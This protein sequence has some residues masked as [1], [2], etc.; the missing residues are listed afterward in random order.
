MEFIE[1]LPLRELNYLANMTYKEYKP[2]DSSSSKNEDERIKNYE[3]MKKTCESFIKA[4]G[5]IKR[6]YKFTGGNNWKQDGSGSGRLFAGCGSIQGLPKKLRGFLLRNTTTDIDMVNCHPVILQYLCNKHNIKSDALQFYNTHREEV[7]SR[8]PDRDKGKET[9]LKAVNDDKLNKKEKD[10]GFKEFDKE[11]KD[12]QK[13]LT[14]LTCYEQIVKDVPEHRLY[15]W[16]GSAINRILCYYENQ[17]LQNVITTIN[18]LN[19]EICCPMFDGAMPYGDFYDNNNLL[20]LIEDSVEKQFEGLNMKFAYKQH[21]N[22]IIMPDDYVIPEKR[23]L[24]LHKGCIFANNDLEASNAIYE[25][26]KGN[27]IYS[28]NTLYYKCNHLWIDNQKAIECELTNFIQNQK[29]YKT[30]SKEEIID[31]VQNIKNAK[32]V[33]QTL[34]N[35]VIS[36]K[37]NGWVSDLTTS[38]LGTILFTNGYY[39]FKTEI[40]YTFDDPDYNHNIKFLELIPYDFTPFSDNEIKQMEVIKNKLFY[41]PFGEEVGDYYMTLIAR[42]L[43]GDKMKKCLFGIGSS[44]TGKSVMTAAIKS[45]F[46]GYYGGFNAINIAYTK[47]GDEAQKL[48]WLL[49]LKTKRIII[50]NEIQMGI[51]IDGNAIKKISNGGNDDIIAR[52][53]QGNETPFELVCLAIIFAND[54]DKITPTDDAVV[55]RVCAIEHKRIC[56]DKKMEECNE[57]EMEKDASLEEYIKTIEFKRVFIGILIQSYLKFQENKRVDI[58]PNELKKCSMAVIGANYDVIDTFKSDFEITDNE[59][60]Y[61]LSSDIEKWLTDKKLKISMMKFGMEIK[62][63][64]KTMNMENID[65]KVQHVPGKKSKRCWIGIKP[66]I[67]T[68]LDV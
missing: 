66:I 16:Y 33:C 49:L 52:V 39:N 56:V 64:A 43:A 62:K 17:I 46:G 51:E 2:Y 41:N 53:H 44:N 45:A 25:L 20:K 42:A 5:E 3:K 14:I 7:L 57:F 37:D 29:I 13:H 58:E 21:K 24:L 28:Q 34:I 26:V 63:Y 47:S 48:R 68:D 60:D 22:D 30:N 8:F 11:C 4:N 18:S 9:F 40:F 31:F 38:S 6:L 67:E 12:I 27:I 1:R 36:L 32:N 10:T 59:N 61:V 54:L 19:I 23:D 15:N 35:K 50:S 55:N 65:N